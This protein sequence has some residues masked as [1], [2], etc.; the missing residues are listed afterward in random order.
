MV[1][2]GDG[3]MFFMPGGFRESFAGAKGSIVMAK[4]TV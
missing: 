1:T 2:H 4:S 3:D